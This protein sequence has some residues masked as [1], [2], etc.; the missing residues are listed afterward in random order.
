VGLESGNSAR[1]FFYA[2]RVRSDRS[3]GT[4]KTAGPTQPRRA[5]AGSQAAASATAS[6]APRSFPS[7]AARRLIGRPEVAPSFILVRFPLYSSRFLQA[8]PIRASLCLG[9]VSLNGKVNG[10][11]LVTLDQGYLIFF[12]CVNPLSWRLATPQLLTGL[13]GVCFQFFFIFLLIFEKSKNQIVSKA[14]S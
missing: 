11:S 5:D 3:H 12:L 9:V 14:G 4:T 2:P 10:S 7:A 8:P 1:K 13:G 6:L